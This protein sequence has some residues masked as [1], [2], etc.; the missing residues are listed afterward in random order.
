MSFRGIKEA[1][2]ITGKRVLL[3]LDLNVPIKNG[4]VFDDYRI[5]ASMPTLNY[6]KKIG[7][8]VVILSHAGE[9]G[10]ETLRPVADYLK[11]PLLPIKV[12]DS[13]KEKIS[14]LQNGDVVMLENLRQDPRE[15]SNDFTFAQELASLGDMYVNDAFSVSHRRHASIVSISKCLPS[16]AGLLFESEVTNL[17]KLFKP[18]HPFL[19]I[20]GG[21]KFETK[22]K[23]VKKFLDIADEVFI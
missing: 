19:F 1:G 16:Y 9:L 17:S 2:D 7:A 13:L 3:R 8:R 21:A 15:I 4:A 12:D 23:L 22:I 18:E 5:R 11:V 14:D 20:L 6:L 10:I